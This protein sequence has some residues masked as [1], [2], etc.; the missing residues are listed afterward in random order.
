MNY[1]NAFS[2]KVTPQNEQIPGTNQVAN[3]AGG[4]SWQLDAWKRLDRFLVLGSEGGTYY[5][6][7]RQLTIEN[8]KNVLD[9]LKADGTRLVKRVVEISD[10]GRAPKNEAAL[11]C[12]ALAC[13]LGDTAT[14]SSALDALPK[15]ARY[16]TDLFKFVNYVNNFRG[17]GRGLRNGIAKWYTGKTDDALAYQLVK[18]RSRSVFGKTWSHVDLLRLGHPKP[19]NDVQHAL[20]KWV[21]KQE[22]S[23]NMSKLVQDFL[24]VQKA[25][26][27]NDVLAIVRDNASITWEMIPTEHVTPEVWDA[28]LPNIKLTALIRNL[29]RL[30]A[31]GV[32]AP[33]SASCKVVTDLL[34]DA[35]SL[36]K[37]R[38]HPISVLGA[39]RT[40]GMGHGVRGSL[41]WQPVAQIIDALDS[42]FYASFGNVEST[43]QRWNLAL[44]VSGSMEW[45]E[46]AGMP[47]LTPRVASAA[48]ALITAAVEKQYTMTAFSHEM[49]PVCI[50]PRQRLDD[51]IEAV[52]GLPF[53]GTDCSLPMLWALEKKVEIDT[54]V[55]YT[56][57]ETWAG[58]IHP[59]QAL[60]K[61]RDKMGIP[62]RLVVV[63]MTSNGFTIASP[64][65]AGMLDVVG[66]DTATPQLISDFSRGV[67]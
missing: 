12:L 37:A 20:F 36:K 49:V 48:L 59:V 51:A 62:A 32:L 46:I 56:D 14:K 43:G 39:L 23:D 21:A 17:W 45:G 5:I 18:Y 53:G 26:S 8:A 40:Y 10:G 7:E 33:L 30:T 2:T 57:S 65:D 31:N 67:A 3:S 61:Y 16:A 24:R 9:C 11:F 44:D 60:Q 47:G 52:S 41:S 19:V 64:D 63:G 13:G 22:V 66:F 54:F 28:L 6:G 29:A 58:V 1:T 38:I 42:A 55:I 35:T 50:S 34:D 25:E 27:S 15:V 4:F